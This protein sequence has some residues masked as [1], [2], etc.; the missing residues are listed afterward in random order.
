M[1]AIS[2]VL[3][4]LLKVGLGSQ[5]KEGKAFG[6]VLLVGNKTSC[7]SLHL[8]GYILVMEIV[9]MFHMISMVIYGHL[10]CPGLIN[11]EEYIDSPHFLNHWRYLYLDMN[12]CAVKCI[13]HKEN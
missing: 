9:T 1:G 8:I 4:C 10:D 11:S 12:L 2:M 3:S 7:N 13:L 6:N 5:V